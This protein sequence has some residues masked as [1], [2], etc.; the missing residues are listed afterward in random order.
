MLYEASNGSAL[1]EE[2]PLDARDK[3]RRDEDINRETSKFSAAN[4]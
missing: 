3:I 2:M 4:D 1:I